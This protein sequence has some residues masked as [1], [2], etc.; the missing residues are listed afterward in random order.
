MMMMMVIV[1]MMMMIIATT[2]TTTTTIKVTL[3]GAIPDCSQPPQS[4]RTV[5]NTYV[6]VATPGHNR[7]QITCTASGAY[8]VQH[9]VCHVVRRTAQLL[10]RTDSKSH[11]F[12]YDEKVNTEV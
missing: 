3:K 8:H 7:V 10:G 2:T 6:Q 4:P 12:S 1:M 5:S 11:L 9:A